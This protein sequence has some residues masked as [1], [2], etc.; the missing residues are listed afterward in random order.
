[1]KKRIFSLLLL[2][3]FAVGC[4]KTDTNQKEDQSSGEKIEKEINTLDSTTTEM[5]KAKKEIEE[6]AEELD[7]AIDDL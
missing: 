1:M 3:L 4:S 2:V 6:S 5:E 7:E